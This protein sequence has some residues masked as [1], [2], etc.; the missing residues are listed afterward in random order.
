MTYSVRVPPPGLPA[1]SANPARLLAAAK[2]RH[3]AA[4]MIP[5]AKLAAGAV[6]AARLGQAYLIEIDDVSSAQIVLELRE[7]G[8]AVGCFA[9]VDAFFAM[10][11]LLSLGCIVTGICPASVDGVAFQREL[12]VCGCIF[13]VV[14]V[15][16][17]DDVMAAVRAMKAGAADV[18]VRPVSAAELG[19]A[20]HGAL[21]S[22]RHD[23][24]DSDEMQSM[25]E[26]LARLTRRERQ[27]LEG[28]VRGE[29]NKSIA[30]ALGISPRTVEVH[31]AKVMEKLACRSLP[32]IVRLVLHV[33]LPGS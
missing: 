30:N 14:A 17:P 23:R 1:R 5:Q 20:V 3:G 16:E 12:R 8:L 25:R 2:S 10:L 7:Y 28:L 4:G 6:A 21:V 32:E 9:T 11:P 22:R 29:V 27:V 24:A 19:L 15:T 33:G 18:V 26:R 13:P 31:R